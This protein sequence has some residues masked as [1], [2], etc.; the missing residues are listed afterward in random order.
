MPTSLT[1]F[2]G[3]QP[4]FFAI[5]RPNTH[6]VAPTAVTPIDPPLMSSSFLML[7]SAVRVK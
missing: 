1:S 4:I 7:G 3:S 2:S 5:M 6:V